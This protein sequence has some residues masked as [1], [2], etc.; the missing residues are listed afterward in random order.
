MTLVRVALA[1]SIAG[2]TGADLAADGPGDEDEP[3][4][5]DHDDPGRPSWHARTVPSLTELLAEHR[6]AYFPQSV[7]ED[8]SYGEVDPVKIDADIYG[9]ARL[10]VDG[11]LAGTDRASLAA[12]LGG[13]R[14][15][16]ESFPTVARPYYERLV[17]IGE[18]ALGDDSDRLTLPSSLIAPDERRLLV[19]HARVPGPRTH[20]LTFASI[21]A[22]ILL[23]DVAGRRRAF[24]ELR[25]GSAAKGFPLDKNMAIVVTDRRLITCRWPGPLSTRPTVLGVV[26]RR[27]VTSARLPFV[28]GAW[29]TVVLVVHGIEWQLLIE[30]KSADAFVEILSS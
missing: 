10:A 25:A 1:G 22:F 24:A 12:A 4:L 26:P 2:A 8:G 21:W 19:A 3:R 11:R 17:Q 30:A 9:W 18:A 5:T 6:L 27:A 16:L 29:R 23:A 28:E 20:A 13:L 14:A 7:V 15:S